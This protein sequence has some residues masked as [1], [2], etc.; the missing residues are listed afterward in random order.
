MMCTTLSYDK[1]VALKQ[2]ESCNPCSLVFSICIYSNIFNT[3]DIL[4]C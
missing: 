3:Q 1:N 4:G 2:T